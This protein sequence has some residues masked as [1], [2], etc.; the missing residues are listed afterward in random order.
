MY[1]ARTTASRS[2]VVVA[3][4]APPIVGHPWSNHDGRGTTK[5]PGQ[6]PAAPDSSL[7]DAQGADCNN[8]EGHA[9]DLALLPAL[10]EHIAKVRYPLG[11]GLGRR[12]IWK[13]GEFGERRAVR[14]LE[15]I[16]G[17][18][19]VPW[20]RLQVRHRAIREAGQE[21]EI[22]GSLTPGNLRV[23]KTISDSRMLPGMTVR[24]WFAGQAPIALV[25]RFDDPVTRLAQMAYLTDRCND[26]RAGEISQV[27]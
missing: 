24:D 5:E 10:F 2:G 19:L 18:A 25:R 3:R 9:A 22:R 14:G 8:D 13:L 12:S 17:T 4:P 15:W 6:N 20:R 21:S 11:T 23:A 27:L 26:G 7:A 1:E 16:S